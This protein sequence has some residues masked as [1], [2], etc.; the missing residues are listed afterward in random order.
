MT[1]NK[2]DD[3]GIL[4]PCE[5]TCPAFRPSFLGITDGISELVDGRN[6]GPIAI[7]NSGQTSPANYDVYGGSHAAF[8]AQNMAS[9]T[10]GMWHSL[11][12]T[13]ER[14]VTITFEYEG[15][16]LSF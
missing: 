5:K 6:Y 7:W 9:R 13:G 14:G 2:R 11:F 4:N 8:P 16:V 10:G 1:R 12:G 3:F 15:R